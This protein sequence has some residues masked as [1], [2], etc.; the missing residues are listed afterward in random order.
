MIDTSDHCPYV[1]DRHDGAVCV[2]VDPRPTLSRSAYPVT[3]AFFGSH[4]LQKIARSFYKS[5]SWRLQLQQRHLRARD[6]TDDH[7][8]QR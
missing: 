6:P 1:V 2:R 5:R 7:P 4:V 3:N 8:A